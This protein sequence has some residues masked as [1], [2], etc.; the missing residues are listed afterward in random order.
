M[1]LRVVLELD[2]LVNLLAN[3]AVRI[4]ELVSLVRQLVD[5]V[6][7]T[8]VL[9]LCLDERS[10]DLI[11]SGDASRLLNLLESIFDHLHVA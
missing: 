7:E 5:V 4:L 3:F 6:K 2:H 9:L 1:L 11:D 8:V 10:N